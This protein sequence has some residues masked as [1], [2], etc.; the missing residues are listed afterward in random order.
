MGL[1]SFR[2]FLLETFIKN[3]DITYEAHKEECADWVEFDNH[4]I[5]LMK[6]IIDTV[7]KDNLSRSLTGIRFLELNRAILWSYFGTMIGAY[8]ITIRELRF[9]LEAMLQAYLADSQGGIERLSKRFTK[10]HGTALIKKCNFDQ[11]YESELIKIYSELCEFVHPTI[12]ELDWG[13]IDDRVVFSYNKEKFNMN[14]KLHRNAYD[15]IMFIT[16]NAFPSATTEYIKKP[17]TISSL[18]M[19]NC[20]ISLKYLNAIHNQK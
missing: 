16:M 1:E 15:A 3:W 11:V 2:E 18:R 5:D 7:P 9:W 6:S 12:K 17:L 10:I 4:W 20:R 13:L 14:R 8:E 19:M